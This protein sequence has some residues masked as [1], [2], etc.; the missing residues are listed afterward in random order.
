MFVQEVAAMDTREKHY[1][2]LGEVSKRAVV[3]PDIEYLLG[4][5]DKKDE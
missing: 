1:C 5:V 4:S 2:T 3:T